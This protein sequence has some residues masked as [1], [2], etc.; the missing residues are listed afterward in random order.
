MLE[1]KPMKFSYIINIYKIIAL[2]S[3]LSKSYSSDVVDHIGALNLKAT[4]PQ[5]AS[6]QIGLVSNGS[7]SPAS[8]GGHS[9]G[10]LFS[11]EPGIAGTKIKTGYQ[12]VYAGMGGSYGWRTEIGYMNIYKD[13]FADYGSYVGIDV[14]G[15][16]CFMVG[17]LGCWASKDGV[18]ASFGIGV[19]F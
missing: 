16:L 17:S 9:T 3:I 8:L 10:L 5:M 1:N 6:L 13:N 2:C 14:S 4:Y 15:D 7:S 18:V 12:D 19:G 11:A